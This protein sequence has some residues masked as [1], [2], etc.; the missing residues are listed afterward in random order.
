MVLMTNPEKPALHGV[1]I[2]TSTGWISAWP[3]ALA[4]AGG[5]A[6]AWTF[7]WQT[8]DLVWNFLVYAIVYA[9]YF[10]P[11]RLVRGGIKQKA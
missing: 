11:W 9:V 3:D 7:R 6:I 1:P 2:Q 8:R 4:F 10:F 5:L